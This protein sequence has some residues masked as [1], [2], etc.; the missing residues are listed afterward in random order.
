MDYWGW[1]RRGT[2]Y[3]CH[4][5]RSIRPLPANYCRYTTE[6]CSRYT[7]Y[8]EYC[9]VI[10]LYYIGYTRANSRSLCEALAGCEAS[11]A[12]TPRDMVPG[13]IQLC[14]CHGYLHFNVLTI[15]QLNVRDLI[16]KRLLFVFLFHFAARFCEMRYVVLL[17][18]KY[19]KASLPLG[20]NE[21]LFR[22][23]LHRYNY[24]M[25]F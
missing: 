15:T 11:E 2:R 7:R 1:L 10:Q 4:I 18:P 20:T 13:Y 8:R 21:H 23:T 16:A 19:C 17:L 12:A 24:E 22:L 5:E 3:L 14:L 9:G 25:L 6:Y